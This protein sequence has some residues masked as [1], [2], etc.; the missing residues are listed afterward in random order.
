MSA[1]TCEWLGYCS[2]ELPAV[3]VLTPAKA[4]KMRLETEKGRDVPSKTAT[5]AEPTQHVG[6]D[7]N[8]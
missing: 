1:C 8:A 2:C 6:E 4:C 3:P 5:A 7:S